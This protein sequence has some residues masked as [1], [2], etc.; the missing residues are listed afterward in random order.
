MSSKVFG[1]EKVSN[2]VFLSVFCSKSI[3]YIDI[4]GNLDNI[5]YILMIIIY[6]QIIRT[7]YL[8]D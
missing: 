1:I 5:S 7:Q 4:C 2:D 3:I 8:Y 6:T